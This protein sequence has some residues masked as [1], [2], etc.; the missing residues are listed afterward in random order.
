MHSNTRIIIVDDHSL[1]REGMKLL[2]EMEGMGHIIAEA[3]NGR[4]FLEL[5]GN[6]QPDLVLM[7]IEMPVMG[8]LEACA[9]AIEIM[10]DLKILVLTM[11]NE[12]GIPTPLAA[13]MMRAPMGRMDILSAQEISSINSSSELVRKYSRVVDRESAYEMLERKIS[14]IE[15]EKADA[16]RRKERDQDA[17]RYYRTGPVR[18]R[19]TI[20]PVVKVLTSATFIRGVMGVLTRAMKR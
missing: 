8:G 13:T 11:L 15:D 3:E 4:I 18:R 19:T 1:F 16:E 9:K 14:N 5:L 10:P 20:N 7:D 17:G 12:K 6:L 2:I